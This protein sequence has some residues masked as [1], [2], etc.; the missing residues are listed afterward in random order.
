MRTLLALFLAVSAL[1]SGTPASKPDP[2]LKGA[3]RR[4]QQGW[5]Q[6]RLQGPPETL[7]FQHGYLL[8]KEIDD[9]V[10][11]LAGLAK[12]NTQRD[13]AFF[14][15][16]AGRMFGPKLGAE[17][18]AEIRG[19]VAG[20]R[21]RGYR[22]DELD[23]LALNGWT[24]LV[25]YYVPDLAAQEKAGAG[26]N[27]APGNCSA[28]IATGGMTRDGKIV[29]GNSA[30]VDYAV[31]ARWNVAWDIQPDKGHR[32][33][34]DGFPGSIQS[35]D[36][37]ALNGAGLLVTETTISGYRS[38]DWS[39][40]PAFVRARRAVQYAASIDDFVR[41][42]GED[43]N[44]AYANTWLVGDLK[45]NEI[46]K[47]DLGLKHQRLWRTK[48]G[49]FV[50]SNFGTDEQ[51]LKA[52]TTYNPKDPK[53]SSVARRARWAQLEASLKGKL[54]AQTGMQVLADHVDT[55]L[56]KEALTRC[57]LCG[58]LDR[59]PQGNAEWDLPPFYP[60]GAT[61]GKV[62][63]AELARKFKWWGRMGHPCGEP[64][65]AAT[66]LEQHPEFRW[67]GSFLI[68]MKRRPWTLIRPW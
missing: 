5:I 29:M 44:G 40:T 12:G 34:M 26:T 22:Y 51:L 17:Y 52:E 57:G 16:A 37:F 1:W 27:K 46:A 6:V 49:I 25:S 32:M 68:D 14:R 67:Q 39:R 3:A 45:T 58:H 15:E 56:G 31:G 30:W 41:I 38:Q 2:R 7:G 35:G 4:E 20:L 55:T 50:G 65:E 60:M 59:D 18:Q 43:N 64:F 21:S 28:F 63:T 9:A 47:L 53:A 42:M 11:T 48:D 61:N 36:D 13:W 19:I 62:T 23:L 10:K 54:D 33:V 24:E 66:F 8:A